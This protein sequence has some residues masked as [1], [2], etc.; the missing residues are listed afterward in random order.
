M[1]HEKLKD[2]G[3]SSSLFSANY[4]FPQDW[5]RICESVSQTRK[6]VLLDDS[7]SVSLW[8]NTM[9]QALTD[10]CPP[11]EK[12]IVSREADIDFGVC[13]DNLEINYAEILTRL[14]A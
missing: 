4:V 3:V 12:I 6:L 7:K 1:L 10:R 13:P 11:F 8:G 9:I 5:Q 14:E 2:R